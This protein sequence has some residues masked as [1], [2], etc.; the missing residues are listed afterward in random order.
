MGIPATHAYSDEYD[1]YIPLVT[2]ETPHPLYN[3]LDERHNSLIDSINAIA[4]FSPVCNNVIGMK[5][6][7][8]D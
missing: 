5:S 8:S 4:M 7:N 1:T 3:T 6:S 2:H